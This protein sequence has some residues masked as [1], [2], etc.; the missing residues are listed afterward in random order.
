M[1]Q[2]FCNLVEKVPLIF[3]KQYVKIKVLIKFNFLSLIVDITWELLSQ[4]VK[5]V[6]NKLQWDY[7]LNTSKVEMFFMPIF[8]HKVVKI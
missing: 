8:Q 4:T 7:F 1:K 6:N 3:V 5:V 2:F